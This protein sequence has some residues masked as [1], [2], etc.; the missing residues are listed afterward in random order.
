MLL[1]AG[2]LAAMV[3]RLDDAFPGIAER[4][5]DETG[6]RREFVN[7]FVNDELIRGPLA[8]AALRPGDAVHILP[9][10]AGG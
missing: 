1:D 3:K 4:I 9:S 8:S 6:Q 7:L 5:V 10:V 2:D